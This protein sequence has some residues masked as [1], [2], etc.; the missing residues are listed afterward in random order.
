MPCR[1]TRAQE[2][3]N[4]N[5]SCLESH[6]KTRIKSTTPYLERIR[7]FR[8]Y[9]LK[10]PTAQANPTQFNG[11]IYYTFAAYLL[12][13]TL[14]LSDATIL[15]GDK[16][17]TLPIISLSVPFLGFFALAPILLV[18]IHAHLLS[19]LNPSINPPQKAKTPS[20]SIKFR[21]NF[22]EIF[23]FTFSPIT[24]AVV[25]WRIADYQELTISTLHLTLISVDIWLSWNCAKSRTSSQAAINIKRA[26]TA[27]ATLTFVKAVVC[28]DVFVRPWP[29]SITR[30]LVFENDY[31]MDAEG[32]IADPF[33]L[34][35][36]ITI[37]R[38]KL[39]FTV[40]ESHLSNIAALH[41]F[42]NWQDYFDERG[43]SVDVR[44]RSLRLAYLHG[45][46]LPR[47][48]GHEAQLQGSNLSY[49]Y[50]PGAV[51]INANLQDA[52]L[53]MTNLNGSYLDGANLREA[54]LGGTRLVGA[55]LDHT[56]FQGAY[57]AGAALTAAWMPNAGF[58]LS[59]LVGTDFSGSYLENV[60]FWGALHDEKPQ[61]IASSLNDQP[62][63]DISLP[64]N[65]SIQSWKLSGPIKKNNELKDA[66]PPE[67][68]H[69]DMDSSK[70][71]LE[72][73]CTD[74]LYDGNKSAV[75]L[76]IRTFSLTKHPL[77][78]TFSENIRNEKKCSA[79]FEAIA[80]DRKFLTNP[81]Q[82]RTKQ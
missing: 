72:N 49:A 31:F 22:E 8:T 35:P 80:E 34:I 17:F 52:N 50:M 71:W 62:A 24:I 75:K 60:K 56:Q 63:I 82:S 57:I 38:T 54:F 7:N 65:S 25:F 41:G 74:P 59:A 76:I 40:D 77:I 5:R 79:L 36:N 2:Q 68:I 58:E 18:T 23:F 81:S 9:A 51:L 66:L 4:L 27:V 73:F 32:K 43:V 44:D 1:I 39:L 21:S 29:D 55:T 19:E 20:D 10:D 78:G 13:T 30:N 64:T 15:T 45:Q 48:W 6:M 3:G 42:K 46:T 37:D 53:E 33:W 11:A 61:Y 70:I 69:S 28:W 14:T 67:F 16:G 12:I 26:I 47:L